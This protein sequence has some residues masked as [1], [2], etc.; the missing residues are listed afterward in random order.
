M[1]TMLTP[2][3]CEGGMVT[4]A[5]VQLTS[6]RVQHRQLTTFAAM[7]E[8]AG[9]YVEAAAQ[10]QQAELHAPGEQSRLWCEARQARCLR[11]APQAAHSYGQASRQR[12]Q[13]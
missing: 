11:M 10:W 1:T 7:L 3:A 2:S 4:E 9:Q 12:T 5:V 8:R 13:V 6:L